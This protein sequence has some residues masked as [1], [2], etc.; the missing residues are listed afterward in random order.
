MAEEGSGGREQTV[1][2]WGSE[3][4]LFDKDSAAGAQKPCF[5]IRI[6][7]LGADANKRNHINGLGV[8][9]AAGV[10][11]NPCFLTRIL[12]RGLRVQEIGTGSWYRKMIELIG[13]ELQPEG[14]RITHN[15]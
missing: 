1:C 13:S 15:K 14:R 3:S 9:W 8:A 6:L 7:Q 11:H 10:A 5:L 2:S 12:Q 4:L